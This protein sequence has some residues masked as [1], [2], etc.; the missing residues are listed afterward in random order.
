M[1]IR[2]VALLFAITFSVFGAWPNGYSYRL[3]EAVDYTKV[4]TEDHTSYPATYI[5]TYTELAHTTHS[6][7]ATDLNGYDII[8]TSDSAGSTQLDHEIES[9][10]HETGA[11]IFH[12]RIPSVSHTANTTFYVWVGNS[13]VTTSQE[14]VAG[15][16]DAN[17]LGVWHLGNGTTLSVAD[18]TGNSS[19][20][21]NGATAATGKVGGGAAV[22]AGSSQYISTGLTP[23]SLTNFTLEAW[24]NEGAD[25]AH[26]PISSRDL[27][28]TG[29]IF[30]LYEKD[31][32][33]LYYG[34]EV[35][36]MGSGLTRQRWGTNLD[37]GTF[38]HVVGTHAAGVDGLTVYVNGIAGGGYSMEHA[39][40]DP[41]NASVLV[42][43]RDGAD[44]TP[45]YFTGS[46]DEVRLSDSVRSTSWIL[47]E[48]NNQSN[49]AT[50]FSSNG[51]FETTSIKSVSSV[52]VG[53]ISKIVGVAIADAAKVS[54]VA[55]Q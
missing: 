5:R 18:S 43:G 40:T 48:Y 44:S 28:A 41:A 38:Y 49:P 1:R 20:T 32:P 26:F 19:G 3:T 16:W 17:F 4:G 29:G 50:F 36:F 15:V 37:I 30:M 53:G 34:P 12:V 55:N 13:S 51:V 21:N 45:Y 46:L 52:S 8:F 54:G 24:I 7:Y 11:V 31:P 10:N 23:S 25:A 27:N 33:S 35:G 42:F 47:A 6:G 9:Y 14:D 22:T 39:A 2:L